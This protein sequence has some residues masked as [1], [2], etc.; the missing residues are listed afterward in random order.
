LAKEAGLSPE[1]QKKFD[2]EFIFEWEI[3]EE[4]VVHT[5]SLRTLLD[6]GL[7]FDN[8]T[9]PVYHRR[10]RTW[11][12]QLPSTSDLRTEIAK[13]VSGRDPFEHGVHSARM[14]KCFGAR[15]PV[16]EVAWLVS[17]WFKSGIFTDK[18]WNA[19]DV[20]IDYGLNDWWRVDPDFVDSL[21]LFNDYARGLEWDL[22]E[23]KDAREACIDGLLWQVFID[24]DICV[25]VSDRK[26]VELSTSLQRKRNMSVR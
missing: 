6:R 15:A 17:R 24:S 25:Q 14:A 26:I 1:D 2:S 20:G 11:R 3:E 22:Q 13:G 8:Y 18:Q 16:E 10:H 12:R 4:Y 21:N 9:E 7:C 23:M 19:V 5:V